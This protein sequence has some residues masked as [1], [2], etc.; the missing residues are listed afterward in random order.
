[1]A[2][3]SWPNLLLAK[4]WHIASKFSRKPRPFSAKNRHVALRLAWLS[5]MKVTMILVLASALMRPSGHRLK[6]AGNKTTKMFQAL[7]TLRRVIL[8]GT[9]IQNDLGE[10][11]AMVGHAACEFEKLNL[12]RETSVTQISWVGRTTYMPYTTFWHLLVVDD[13]GTFKRVYENPILASRSPDCSSK[14]LELGTTRAAQVGPCPHA[15]ISADILFSFNWLQKLSYFD[16]K[17]QFCPIIY[18]PNVW[19]L[20]TCRSLSLT[21]ILDEYVVFVSPTD[22]QLSMMT[23]LLHPDN[24]HSFASSTAKSLA[25]IGLLSKLC[26]SPYLLKKNGEG[27]AMRSALE[28][29]PSKALPEDVSLSG[30]LALWG[31]ACR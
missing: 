28:L 1:M 13:Y 10:F 24:L 9:P 5:V 30:K 4:N 17:P 11:H 31:S 27:T 7:R 16:G 29:I 19:A 20:P 15:L 2:A 18:R 14:A 26:N 22:L 23:K 21:L 6:S 8:S 25:L 3:K 12:S